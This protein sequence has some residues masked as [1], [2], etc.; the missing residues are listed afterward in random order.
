[1]PPKTWHILY[2]V[3]KRALWAFILPNTAQ[4]LY[5]VKK[6]QHKNLSFYTIK[7]STHLVLF[8]KKTMSFYTTKHDTNFVPCQN[9]STL[10]IYT[11]K[12]SA[13]FVPCQ[14]QKSNLGFYTNKCSTNFV[15]CQKRP[16]WAFTWIQNKR[17]LLVCWLSITTHK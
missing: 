12:C 1:M 7:Y 9:R 6:K 14:K 4:I 13:N 11:T 3:K 8:Q 2:L 15:P 10:S 5:L 17:G 16:I